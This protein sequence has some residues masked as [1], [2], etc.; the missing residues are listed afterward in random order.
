MGHK[1]FICDVAV[2]ER[3]IELPDA[4]PRCRAPF[5]TGSTDVDSIQ[6]RPTLEKLRLITVKGEGHTTDVFETLHPKVPP[7]SVRMPTE[8]HCAQCNKVVGGSVFRMYR[9]EDVDQRTAG[10]LR[11]LLYDESARDPTVQ[12]KCFGTDCFACGIEAEIGT[13]EVPHPV[14]VRLHTCKRNNDELNQPR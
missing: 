4:C 13:E 7:N 5:V 12:Q 11:G 8:F 6:L 14:D 9:L 1:V 2:I 10:K 3:K